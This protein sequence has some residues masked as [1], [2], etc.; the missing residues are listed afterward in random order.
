MS[1]SNLCWA[2]DE[3][4]DQ[5]IPFFPKQPKQPE[6][7]PT[8]CAVGFATFGERERT[9]LVLWTSS[10]DPPKGADLDSPPMFN[11]ELEE[12]TEGVPP[13]PSLKVEV[14]NQI[15]E[16]IIPCTLSTEPLCY[17]PEAK[18]PSPSPCKLVI[19]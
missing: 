8:E 7:V 15:T 14:K 19:N 10:I 3:V 18:N 17:S 9:S 6:V 5:G 12:L 2:Y 1:S 11:T 13:S 16:L 4:D